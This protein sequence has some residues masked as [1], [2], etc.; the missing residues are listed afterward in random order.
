ML[1]DAHR[2]TTV[3]STP[4]LSHQATTLP[5]LEYMATSHSPNQSTSFISR[6]QS[7]NACYSMEGAVKLLRTGASAP[8]ERASAA[9]CSRMPR[10]ARTYPHARTHTSQNTPRAYAR[11]R[12]HALT[13][14]VH[15]THATD[16]H[17]KHTLQTTHTT[18]THAR[19]RAR[20]HTHS[21][22]RSG[23]RWASLSA[24]GP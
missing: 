19:A 23:R 3:L 14:K 8:I 18:R 24:M 1:Q 10:R 6:S 17:Q 4:R 11:A 12:T 5:Y 22:S 9:S 2:I 16:T 13:H 20:A 21:H 7:A 15:T